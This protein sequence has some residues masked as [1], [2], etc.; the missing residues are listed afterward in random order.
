MCVSVC[1]PFS[2]CVLTIICILQSPVSTPDLLGV[3]KSSQC[4]HISPWVHPAP[5]FSPLRLPFRRA[6]MRFS[7]AA[8]VSFIMYEFCVLRPRLKA[9]ARVSECRASVGPLAGAGVAPL[10]FRFVAVGSVQP[11]LPASA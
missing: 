7:V 3:L 4:W 6:G 1:G 10:C 2:C 8:S 9:L 11:V 5:S